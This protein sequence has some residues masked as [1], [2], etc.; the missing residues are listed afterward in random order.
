[1]GVSVIFGGQWGSEG[2]GKTTYFF[3]N[4]LHASTVV[5]VGGTNSGHT[6]V[7]EA[8]V[9][10]AFQ[11]LPVAALLEGITCVLPAGSYIDLD[12]LSKEIEMC[13]LE[14]K[15][16]KIHPNAI[17]ISKS[18]RN[19]E[20]EKHLNREIG[21]TESGTG[22]AVISRISRNQNVQLAKYTEELRPYLC[23]TDEFLRM[24]L[25]HSHEVIIEGTQGFGLSVLHSKEYPYSTSRDTSAAAFVSEAG[26]SPFDVK[27]IIMTLRAFPI[28]VAGN[29]GPLP[30]ET[31]WEEITQSA[32]APSKILE[33]TTV[34]KKLRR[35]AKFDS[36][37]VKRSI[38]SNCPN[39][40]V[41]NHCDYFDY[42]INN[43]EI[44]STQAEKEIEKIE[45]QIGR[46]DY[47]GTGDRTLFSRR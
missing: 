39:I 2:K 46:I 4:K 8:G 3:A 18:N 9:R 19:M 17:I 27:K 16:L 33:Y 12:I 32:K 14:S 20:A 38:I 13:G 36:D 11:T 1:M 10:T 35:V 26:V 45:L 21:S 44:I 47:I 24:E 25:R 31:T 15:R 37:V 43:K 5:R 42:S 22:E 41:L 23:D 6:V 28:R 29:S 40:V 34:T 7:N 30:N